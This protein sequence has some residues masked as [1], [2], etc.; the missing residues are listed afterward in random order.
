RR[1]PR[2]QP[3]AKSDRIF[4]AAGTARSDPQPARR[5]RL[6]RSGHAAVSTG[7]PERPRDRADHRLSE[8]HGRQKAGAVAAPDIRADTL[9]IT[10]GFG[11]LLPC[12]EIVEKASPIGS[13]PCTDCSAI[14]PEPQPQAQ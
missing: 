10:P 5:A 6:A 2:P 4:H 8:A 14:A 11:S 12:E 1:R 7:P 13:R 9:A 3:A